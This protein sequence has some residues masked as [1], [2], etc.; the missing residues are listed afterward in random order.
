MSPVI[1][2]EA[3]V[4]YEQMS[5]ADTRALLGDTIPFNYVIEGVT[6]SAN[7]VYT[8]TYCGMTQA[9]I[10]SNPCFVSGSY[11]FNTQNGKWLVYT[12]DTNDYSLSNKMCQ[13]SFELDL[14]AS[15]DS[16][17][18]GCFA[19]PI[20]QS[21]YQSPISSDNSFSSYPFNFVNGLTDCPATPFSDN[22]P[23]SDYYNT[24]LF[25][26]SNFLNNVMSSQYFR[27][28]PYDNQE[29]V[30]AVVA[31]GVAFPYQKIVLLVYCPFVYGSLSN[32]NPALT[33]TTTTETSSGGGGTTIIINNST[34]L[35]NT[36]SLI[37]Q[38]KQSVIN[39]GTS[40]IN[41]IKDLFIPDEEFVE[42]WVDDLKDLL[43]DHLGGLYQAG[44]IFTD[45]FEEFENATASSTIEI[46][47]CSIPLAG[48]TLTLGPYLVPLKV[49]G[50]PQI[51]Y[52]GIAWI[53]DFLCLWAFLHMCRTKLEIFL[54]PESEAIKE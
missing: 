28:F 25:S 46:P 33:T 40:I 42:D 35:T 31:D 34:D 29:S 1:D 52:D 37:E 8:G 27:L 30:T 38:V 21:V 36:N 7:F 9:N 5:Q 19:L 16:Q 49:S 18:Y 6:N 51:L 13:I 45:I 50:M 39:L 14:Y 17:F 48:E 41:G 23:N 26:Y 15:S 3:V 54:V 53:T 20:L 24:A 12:S 32:D 10:G 11:N 43:E 47:A 2:A 22:S 4:I 44:E